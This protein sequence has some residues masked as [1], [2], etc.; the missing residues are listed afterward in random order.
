MPSQ[1]EAFYLETTVKTIIPDF[2]SSSG[3]WQK[4]K[5]SGGKQQF[6]QAYSI[7][8]KLRQR[9]YG[10][11]NST[12]LKSPTYMD[13]SLSRNFQDFQYFTSWCN[14][15]IGY[16][17]EGYHLDKDILVDGNRVYDENSCVFIPAKLNTF[18]CNSSRSRGIYPIGVSY[19]PNCNLF[20]SQISVDG[21]RV[22]LGLFRTVDEAFVC[23]KHHKEELGK[24]WHAR[25]ASGEYTVDPRV[26]SRMQSW[27]VKENPQWS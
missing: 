5:S 6:T 15:Q 9:T 19:E 10:K 2:K 25:L 20:K 1:L 16:G 13:C 12:I 21:R 14:T 24:D 23:Y 17:V 7:W 11:N 18:L 26:I 22:H 27:V 4:S 8:N 3:E